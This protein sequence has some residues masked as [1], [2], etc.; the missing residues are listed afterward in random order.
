MIKNVRTVFF[1]NYIAMQVV[2]KQFGLKNNYIL[3]PV[4]VVVDFARV[5]LMFELLQYYS[6]Q[7]KYQGLYGSTIN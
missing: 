1:N 7:E 2:N 5:A 6:S 3:L 4:V